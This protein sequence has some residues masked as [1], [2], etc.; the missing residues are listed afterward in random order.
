[1]SQCSRAAGRE[2]M[3]ARQRIERATGLLVV[4]QFSWVAVGGGFG[5]IIAG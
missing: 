4:L 3:A 5:P 2:R 1:M